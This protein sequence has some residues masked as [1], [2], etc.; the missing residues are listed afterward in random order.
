MTA[1]QPLEGVRVVDFGQ[2]IAIPFCAQ[3]LAWAGADVITVESSKHLLMRGTPPFAFGRR[4]LNTSGGYNLLAGN[5]RSLALDLTSPQAIKLVKELVQISDVV[6]ENYASH[7]M[8]KLGLGY[9]ALRSLKPDLIMLSLSVFGRT[10]PIKDYIGHH[11]A[12]NLFSGVATLTGYD[13]NDRPRI[14]GSYFP[15]T[16]SGT[17]AFLAIVQAAYYRQETGKGQWIDLSMSEAMTHLI[18]DAIARYTRFGLQ[19]QPLG[20]RDEYAAPN[21]VYRCRGRD[22]WVA[23]SVT[24]EEE[25]RALCLA[26]ERPELAEDAR[27]G[28][29]QSRWDHHGELDTIITRWTRRRDHAEVMDVLQRHGVPAG[30]SL[31]AR[32]LLT[33]RHLR[34]RRTVVRTNH[35]EAGRRKTIGTPWK[36]GSLPAVRYRAAP[37]LG[38]HS[39]EIL[40]DLLG[41]PTE[42]IQRMH[43]EGML[44]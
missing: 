41:L 28:E 37:C 35:P 32:E 9:A 23:I 15:D 36:I 24:N 14:L 3:L 29:A 42:K 18:P 11:S 34:A 1:E 40:R 16:F 5:K 17:A 33:D 2:A 8:E 4:G 31:N 25:W 13:P 12:V 21:G 6:V 22:S 19:Q 20:N 26:M 38:E 10:G 39:A 43:D 27:F 44:S 30:A 7:T